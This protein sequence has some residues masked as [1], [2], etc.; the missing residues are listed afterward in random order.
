MRSLTIKG[1]PDD[2]YR[3]LKRRAAERRR[4]INSEVLVC[5]DRA[6]RSRPIDPDA[7]LARADTLRERLRMPPWTAAALRHARSAGRP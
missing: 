2:L 1:L 5:L 6:L 4:S 3:L 7:W